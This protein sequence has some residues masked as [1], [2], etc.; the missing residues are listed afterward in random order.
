VPIL[1][2][3][4]SHLRTGQRSYYLLSYLYIYGSLSN[5]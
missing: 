1:S 4:F 2:K 3:M 5:G